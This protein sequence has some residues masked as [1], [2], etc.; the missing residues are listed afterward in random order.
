[1][2]LRVAKLLR[3]G[4]THTTASLDVYNVF[5]ANPVLTLNSA[6][7][8]W[9]RPLSIPNARWAKLVLQFEF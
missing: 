7:A 2:Q 3:L 5:N 8:T 9:Q 6:F 1:M 4:G